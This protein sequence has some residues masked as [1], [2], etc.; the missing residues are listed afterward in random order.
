M[1]E[2]DTNIESNARTYSRTFDR[3][4][5]KGKGTK[6]WDETGKTYLD[7]LSCAGA[8]PLGHNNETNSGAVVEFL[9]S[10][11]IQ[12]GL[13]LFTPAREKFIE[14][15]QSFLPSEFSAQMKI[16]FCGP[17][18]SDAIEAIIKLMTIATGRR[19]IIAFRGGYHGMTAG[20]LSLMGNLKVKNTLPHQFTDVQFLP[21]PGEMIKGERN[22]NVIDWANELQTLE[23]ILEDEEGGVT[24]PAMVIL[25]AVQGEGGCI[26]AC[27]DWLR[28]VRELTARHDVPLVIDEVQS[29]LG[30][31]GMGFAFQ[32]Y[33]IIPDAIALSKAL[34]GGYP[35]AAIAYLAKY[36][37]WA[38]GA[39]TGTFRGNQIAM[40]AG[41]EMINILQT[42]SILANVSHRSTQIFSRLKDL[43]DHNGLVQSISG[44]GLMIGCEIAD[45]SRVASERYAGNL[46]QRVK[47]RCFEQ[48]L[49]VETGGR[50]G[51]VIRMLPPLNVSMD[52]VD[53]ALDIFEMVLTSEICG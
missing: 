46:S 2:Y 42:S 5:V 20:S 19:S 25:E 27:R 30:R 21:Y 24:K 48:G 35:L 44:K 47:R 1:K 33:G 41:R 45:S 43:M 36:D 22:S 9:A 18:G 16:H 6:V 40:V 34:G 50:G 52:E 23:G 10:D 49:I 17:T 31:S 14:S 51:G 28:G 11:Q 8:L 53:E 13:D 37:K 15:L 38:P 26:P 3:R 39:H 4:I 32:H 7:F 12:Q 29:G